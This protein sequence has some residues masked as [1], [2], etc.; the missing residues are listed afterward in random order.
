MSINT[1]ELSDILIKLT[2]KQ[3][4]VLEAIC[5][6]PLNASSTASISRVKAEDLSS[7]GGLI[8]SLRRVKVDDGE[9]LIRVVSR[10]EYGKS[11]FGIN[12]KVIDKG[13]LLKALEEINEY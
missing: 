12:K 4:R 11:L 8:G 10:D 6:K 3:R 7:L 5:E 2:G 1:D 13:T 9:A